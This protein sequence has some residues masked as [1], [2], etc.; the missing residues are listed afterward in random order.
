MLAFPQAQIL[1]VTGPLE[2]FARSAR[3]LCEHHGA[4]SP[5]YVTEVAAAR[6]GPLAM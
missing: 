6:A 3:W 4:A 5:A 1:D 2:V